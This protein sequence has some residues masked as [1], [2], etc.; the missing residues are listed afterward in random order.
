MALYSLPICRWLAGNQPSQLSSE[1]TCYR[2]FLGRDGEDQNTVLDVV[3][4]RL[5]LESSPVDD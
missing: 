3:R 4:N 5:V 1:G 2:L